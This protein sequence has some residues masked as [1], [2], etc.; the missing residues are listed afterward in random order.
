M[1]LGDDELR[2]PGQVRVVEPH[3]VNSLAFRR[4][5]GVDTLIFPESISC[6]TCMVGEQRWI[7]NTSG[8]ESVPRRGRDFAQGNAMRAHEF[9]VSKARSANFPERRGRP[10]RRSLRQA[11]VLPSR[12][13]P[14]LP[15][16]LYRRCTGPGTRAAIRNRHCRATSRASWPRPENSR[17]SG[18]NA[19]SGF[20]ARFGPLLGMRT[21][22]GP[23]PYCERRRIVAG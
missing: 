8:R 10:T 16:R 21:R 18:A 7:S 13:R 6:T 2:P 22:V 19:S 4:R 1:R 23:V 20:Q 9:S 17:A 5:L 3:T 11:Q 14:H 15:R 12:C